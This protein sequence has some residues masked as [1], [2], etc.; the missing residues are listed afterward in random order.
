MLENN[1][2]SNGSPS[3]NNNTDSYTEYLDRA[4]SA[5]ANGDTILG[6]HLY[7]AAYERSVRDTYVA[8][9]SVIDGMRHAWDLACQNKERSLAEYIFEKLE[10]YLS[11]EE[12]S[13]CASQLQKLALDKLEEFGLN[14]EDLEEMTDII[15]QDFLGMDPSSLF[16]HLDVP[17]SVSDIA[18]PVHKGLVR[19]KQDPSPVDEA[20]PLPPEGLGAF[21]GPKPAPAA[22]GEGGNAG[23]A[24]DEGPL[25]MVVSTDSGRG[26]AAK[27]RLAKD[28][29]LPADAQGKKPSGDAD[30][31]HSRPAGPQAPSLVLP[32]FN[33]F[34]E[35]RSSFSSDAITTYK[36]LIG[37]EE[38]IEKMHG[39][40]IGMQD[41]P[42]FKQLI[43]TLNARHGL[44]RAPISDIFLFRAAVREDANQ[45]MTA[46]MGEIRLPVVRM[47]ME[48]NMQ[49]L[50]ILCVM[51]SSDNQ[52]RLNPGRNPFEHGGVLILEDIDLWGPP[53]TDMNDDMGGFFMMQLSRGAREAI[54][55]I[56]AAVDNPDVYILASVGDEGEVDDFFYDLLGP[57]TVID[58]DLPNDQERFDLWANIAQEHPSVYAIDRKALVKYSMGMSRFDIYMAAR[59][60]VEEAYKESLVT[61]SY[62][63]VTKENIFEK[64][65]LYQP[66]ESDEYKD[67]EDAVID[68][69]KADL[70]HIDDLLMGN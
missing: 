44:S 63:P 43:A 15:S 32:S 23:N 31:K 60:A 52:Q 5:C 70:D 41:D 28:G 6:M 8:D 61:R 9:P 69:F 45:F 21:D 46:T 57:M 34:G 66:L 3:Q 62:I 38:A 40:G 49:G 59:E 65:A 51:A 48:E 68:S 37:Y 13:D 29:S 25:D 14:R 10:P 30:D 11:G 35:Q 47:R 58:I 16:L 67:L 33:A 24:G 64:I 20:L 22:E 1:T 17:P 19:S 12:I 54:N 39:Y 56:H 7:L 55:L 42:S 2:D 53:L 18:G 26:P 36:D 4:A 50:P 27:A